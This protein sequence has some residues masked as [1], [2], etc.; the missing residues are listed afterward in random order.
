[1]LED[2]QLFLQQRNVY[3]LFHLFDENDVGYFTKRQF[4]DLI[5]ELRKPDYIRVVQ[6]FN[7]VYQAKLDRLRNPKKPTIIKTKE[8]VE[9]PE[10]II[11]EKIIY[12]DKIVYEDCIVQEQQQ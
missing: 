1:M 6:N 3:L 5:Y 8:Y 11:Q 10:Q 12:K 9:V 2:L 4:E 7:I